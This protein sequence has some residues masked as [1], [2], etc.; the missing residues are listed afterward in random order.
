MFLIIPIIIDISKCFVESMRKILEQKK[1]LP[2]YLLSQ[3]LSDMKI[4]NF[5][6]L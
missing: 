5:Y 1:L 3:Y 6:F 2:N 4:T